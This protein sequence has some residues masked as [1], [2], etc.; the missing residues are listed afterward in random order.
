MLTKIIQI[1]LV[2]LPLL[3]I[4]PGRPRHGQLIVFMMIALAAVS[5]QIKNIWLRFFGYYIATWVVVSWVV[6]LFNPKFG[7]IAFLTTDQATYILAGY[8]IL[9]LVINSN[10]KI[11]FFYNWICVAVIAQC[12]I[13]IPQQ[14]GCFPYVGFLNYI[15]L[16]TTNPVANLA[17]GT[18]EN[19][20]FF[21]AFIA[22]SLPFF[23][24]KYWCYFIPVIVYHLVL[25]TTTTAVV[26][27]LV[28]VVVLYNTWWVV[29]IAIIAGNIFA[30]SDGTLSQVLGKSARVDFCKECIGNIKTIPQLIFG[31]GLGVSWG[32]GFPLHNE[33]IQGLFEIGVVGMGLVTGYVFT[34]Y[35]QNK[36]LFAAFCAACV[37]CIGNYPI[38]LPPSAFLIIIIIGLIERERLRSEQCNQKNIV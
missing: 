12:L 4:S 33:W 38:H 3:W 32:Q 16:K 27:A 24:R 19:G 31:H 17:V 5:S 13:A 30:Y 36:I 22:I 25:S 1:G 37:N 28:G 8:I 7:I 6:T 21:A 9:L 14:Y 11:E 23:F 20:N 26:A 10:E 29:I 34:V 2:L 35:R 18:L 15:G